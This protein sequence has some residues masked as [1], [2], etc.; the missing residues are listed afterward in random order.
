[1]NKIENLPLHD[2]I[3]EKIIVNWSGREV[4]I[5]LKAFSKAGK[6][7]IPHALKFGQVN[8]IQIP[9]KSPWGESKFINAV[10]VKNDICK[11]E[12]QSGD[13]IYISA[14]RFQ[15]DESVS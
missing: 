5:I 2:A 10:S 9:H 15:F 14:E 1:M 13:E 11:I 3:L 4:T 12:M 8:D 6:N 7:A